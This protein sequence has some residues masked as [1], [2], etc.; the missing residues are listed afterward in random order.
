MSENN[1]FTDIR[2][3]NTYQTVN[4]GNQ[5]WMAENLK[6]LPKVVPLVHYHPILF[7]KK[8]LNISNSHPLYYVYGNNSSK[9]NSAKATSNY[10]NYGVLYNWVA[11]IQACPEGWHLPSKEEWRML[12]DYIKNKYNL[13]NDWIHTDSVGNALKSR[14]QVDSPLGGP[15]SAIV[16]PR[17][18]S[19]L[20]PS[21]ER[22][23]LSVNLAG[24]YGQDM[25]NFSA[26]PGGRAAYN[27]YFELGFCGFWWSSSEYYET[28]A[29]CYM[30][31]HEFGD[32]TS[33]NF[34]KSAGMSIRCIKNS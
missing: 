22:K 27:K 9:L 34:D 21:L 30:M 29:W 18:E 33:F 5:C 12:I 8:R 11:A 26:L 1:T 13:Y 28:R 32:I 15:Y 14:S 10:K 23:T 24:H 6:F 17:W 2:D 19:I 31:R 20:T 3:G 16:H 25:I 7:W 4:I